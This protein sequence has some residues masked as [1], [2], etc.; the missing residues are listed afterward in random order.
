MTSESNPISKRPTPLN[1]REEAYVRMESKPFRVSVKV[2]RNL[3]FLGL[4][5]S[6]VSRKGCTCGKSLNV[7]CVLGDFGLGLRVSESQAS[8]FRI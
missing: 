1:L 7:L 4:K 6:G 3:N 2:L 5:V 8:R